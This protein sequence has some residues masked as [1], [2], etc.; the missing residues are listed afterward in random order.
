MEDVILHNGVSIQL[1]PSAANAPLPTYSTEHF[2][3]ATGLCL[4]SRLYQLHEADWVKIPEK[5]GKDGIK[6][7]DYCFTFQSS[8]G[9]EYV[10]LE[11]KGNAKE[12]NSKPTYLSAHSTSI[13]AKKVAQQA[14]NPNVAATRYGTIAVIDSRPQSILKCWL[15]D[16]PAISS[17]V[18]P[19]SFRLM[20][21][22]EFLSRWISFVA[23]QTQLAAT[24]A[25]RVADFAKMNDPFEL[26]GSPL[27][28]GRGAPI[29]YPNPSGSE[30]FDGRTRV[31]GRAAGGVLVPWSETHVALYGFQKDIV[32]LATS[33]DF[34]R[35]LTYGFNAEQSELEVECYISNSRFETLGLKKYVA[36]KADN[37]GYHAFNM[38]GLLQFSSGGLVF[39]TLPLNSAFVPQL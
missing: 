16:P 33:Q 31:S 2:G 19:R 35:I 3:E 12:D 28:D 22:M 8:N 17:D 18:N 25:T 7:L 37:S 39:G 1:P 11:T 24:L 5:P 9:N 6:T 30:F 10:E 38:R 20:T 21:R 13:R 26:N 23:P 4:L 36:T 15:L 27:R 34:D 14:E 32:D 29:K